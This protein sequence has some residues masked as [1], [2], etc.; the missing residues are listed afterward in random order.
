MDQEP[1]RSLEDV[2]KDY[3][4]LHPVDLADV[5]AVWSW[6]VDELPLELLKEKESFRGFS[7]SRKEDGWLLCVRLSQEGVP[8]VV[9]SRKATPTACVQNLRRRWDL[10]NI[11]F[12]EDRYA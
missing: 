8:A 3:G 4:R 10:R 11:Q 2:L 1:V 7:F 5:G 9:Y 6:L 12:F